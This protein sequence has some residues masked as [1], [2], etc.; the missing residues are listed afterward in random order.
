[1]KGTNLSIAT[2]TTA[3]LKIAIYTLGQSATI[4]FLHNEAIPAKNDI[5]NEKYF[6]QTVPVMH[7]RANIMFVDSHSKSH[8]SHHNLEVT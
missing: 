2:R 1:M 8:C 4:V 3:L 7:H 6:I 5:R